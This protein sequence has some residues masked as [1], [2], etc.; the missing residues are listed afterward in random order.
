MLDLKA[1][2]D[3][4]KRREPSKNRWNLRD[5]LVAVALFAATAGVILW[6]NAHVAVLW[7]ISYILNTAT[8]IA[9]GQIPY[10]DFP[11]AQAPLTFLV[12]AAI[13]RL[14]GRVFFHHVLYVATVGGL[15]TVLTWRIALET[16]RRRVPAAWTLSLLLAAPLIFLSVYSIMP[17][18]EYDSD[19]AFSILIAVWALQRIA[20]PIGEHA[21]AAGQLTR[22]FAAGV[23]LC[24]PLF[25]KQ[26]MGLPF[27]LVSV[28]AILLVLV[29]TLL[30]NWSN[31]AAREFGPLPALGA[32]AGVCVTLCGSVFALHYTT[33]LHNYLRWTIKYAGQRRLPGL[34]DMAGVYWYPA[35][36]W[37]LPCAIAGLVI[38]RTPLGKKLWAQVLA[39]LLFAAPFLFGVV[40]LILYDDADSRGDSFLMIWPVLLLLAT[41]LALVNLVRI[42][43]EP[44][45]R[46]LLPLILLAAINGTMMSQQLWGS[47][48]GIWPLLVLLLAEMLVSLDRFLHWADAS[49][50]L[51]PALAALVSAAMLVCGGFYSTS[52]ERLSYAQFPDGPAVHSAFP[53]L[54]GMSTPGPFLPEFDELM[55]YAQA[56]IPFNDGIVLMLGEDPFFFATG[57]PQRFPTT[58]W[59]HTCLPYSPAQIASLAQS[60]NMRWLIVKTDPQLNEDPT[61][62][63]AETISLLR[64]EFTL[65]AHLQGYDVYRAAPAS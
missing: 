64:K 7:D 22:G 32:L 3:F 30:P 18:P 20:R 34:D 27:L 12:Q 11:L 52:E 8:R 47:T 62:D 35:V 60:L 17:N 39:L 43:R 42:G 65:A 55:R 59:D 54:A 26:N 24:V 1:A 23:L 10:R 5:S 44:S 63:R 53:A 6:Q 29:A 33:G 37:M 9:G 31:R 4:R 14:S 40:A 25:F 41:A 50:R 15:S 13:I 46:A 28:F 36:I 19:C 2:F 16:L 61:P 58:I 51:T 48:Y 49:R 21:G 45:L 56:N 57:R 38:L